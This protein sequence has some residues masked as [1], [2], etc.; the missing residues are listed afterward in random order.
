MPP[1]ISRLKYWSEALQ[2]G[3]VGV[4]AEADD[5]HCLADK[6]HRDF[7]ASQVVQPD[8]LGGCGSAVLAAGFV[9][10]GQGPQLHALRFGAF[11]KGFRGQGAV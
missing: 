5:V 4:K 1:L 11:S 9:V 2:G 3:V 7:D 6:G 8:S 10:I